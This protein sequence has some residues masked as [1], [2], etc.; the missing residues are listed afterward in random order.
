[1]KSMQCSILCLSTLAV[2]HGSYTAMGLVVQLALQVCQRAKHFNAGLM[3]LTS[4]SVEVRLTEVCLRVF[5]ATAAPLS[6]T[7]APVVGRRPS[8]GNVPSK[9]VMSLFR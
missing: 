8:C 1:M 5:H 6:I 7:A 2:D 3:A 9:V 4:A